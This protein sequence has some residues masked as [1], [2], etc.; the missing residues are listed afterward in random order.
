MIMFKKYYS[1]YPQYLFKILNFI[2]FDHILLKSSLHKYIHITKNSPKFKTSH[3]RL[4]FTKNSKLICTASTL[5][6]IKKII[7]NDLKEI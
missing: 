5:F 3:N 2:L 6:R 7:I 4:I 1:M